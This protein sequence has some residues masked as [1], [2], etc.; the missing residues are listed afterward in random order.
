MIRIGR[1]GPKFSRPYRPS[2]QSPVLREILPAICVLL[3][4][5]A[6]VLQSPG[7]VFRGLWRILLSDAGLITD[8]AVIGG[9]GAAFL[10]AALVLGLSTALVYRLKLPI[11]GLTFACLFMMMGFSFLGKNILNILPILAGGWLYARHQGEK[12]S[13]YVYLTLFST[14]LSPMVSYWLVHLQPVV[15]WFTMVIF[16]LII[17]FYMPPIAGYT[18]RVHQGYDLYNVGF[19]AGFLGLGIASVC[20]CVG[21]DFVTDTTW[22]SEHLPFLVLLTV[23]LL[24]LFAAGVYF[25]CRKVRDYKPLLRHSGRSVADFVLMDGPGPTLVNMA[26]TGAIGLGYLLILYPF[27]VRLNGPLACCV[28]SMTGFAAFGKHPRNVVPVM[29]GAIIAGGLLVGVPLTKPSCLLAVLFCTGLAPIA[30]QFGWWWGIVAGFLHMTIVQYT[31]VL[32]GGLN[33]YNNG[34]AA[35]LVCVLLLPIIEAVRSRPKE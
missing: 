5:M 32:H 13:K 14:C 19:A 18:V 6:F 24:G 25:G 4:V 29:L 23:I 35:G 9:V 7:E 30:G 28:L 27:G 12:F 33:L 26:L 20:K 17:G 1:S 16:G 34:F 2:Q 22:G 31:A 15:R 21:V 10:N 11:T 8:P 3:A